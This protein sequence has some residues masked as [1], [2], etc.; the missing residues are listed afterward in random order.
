MKNI[1][2][3]LKLHLFDFFEIA[4]NQLGFIS[5]TA[6]A[7][8]LFNIKLLAYSSPLIILIGSFTKI[9]SNSLG[10]KPQILIGFIVLIVLEF[11][12]GIRA[13]LLN[14]GKIQSRKVTRIFTKLAIYGF[15]LF[16]LN[17]MAG[18]EPFIIWG[19]TISLW[20]YIFWV[21]FCGISFKLFISIL[22]NLDRMGW[23]E[24]T[25]IHKFLNG[26]LKLFIDFDR[27]KTDDILE[28]IN[29]KLPKNKEDK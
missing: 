17:S 5:F 15:L 2:I 28:K 21:F 4:A 16:G 14:G 26:K 19:F 1:L 18:I 24:T 8:S 27:K 25:I 29:N 3:T 7:K 11:F 20:D 6:L 22:E 12:T 13:S 10:L 23:K 9:L